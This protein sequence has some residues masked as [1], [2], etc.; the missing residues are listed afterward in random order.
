MIYL[1]SMFFGLLIILIGALLLLNNWGLLEGGFWG[2]FWPLLLVVI[3]LSIILRRPS[4]SS[5]K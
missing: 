1:Q 4:K 5:K 2:W 3:G